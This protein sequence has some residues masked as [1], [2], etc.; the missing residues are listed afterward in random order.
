MHARRYVRMR[1][2]QITRFFFFSPLF[3]RSRGRFRLCL[4][5]GN[6]HGVVDIL[7]LYIFGRET[8]QKISG[9][10][11]FSDYGE[12]GDSETKYLQ[13]ESAQ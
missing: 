11:Y 13:S 9:R 3:V 8:H 4:S 1:V 10:G 6:S 2:L 7:K 5:A 12:V